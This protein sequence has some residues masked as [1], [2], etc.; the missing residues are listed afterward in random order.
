MGWSFKTILNHTTHWAALTPS[1]RKDEK[2]IRHSGCVEPTED[3]ERSSQANR[4]K[5]LCDDVRN[6]HIKT[7][8]YLLLHKGA[9]THFEITGWARFFPPG[10]TGCAE[11][12]R[13]M[14][15]WPLYLWSYHSQVYILKP[16]IG[17]VQVSDRAELKSFK[18]WHLCWIQSA[19]MEMLL[20]IDQVCNHKNWV[21]GNAVLYLATCVKKTVLPWT[22]NT[23]GNLLGI[24]DFPRKLVKPRFCIKKC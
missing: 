10:C 16:L 7:G 13:D 2:L 5:V 21:D 3:A 20:K 19:L 15:S 4:P 12:N 14:N 6:W 18:I 23:S 24:Q 22:G 11:Q 1:S 9:S 17:G 8:N